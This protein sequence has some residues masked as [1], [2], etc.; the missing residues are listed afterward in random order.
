MKKILI[1]TVLLTI[2]II[3]LG[4]MVTHAYTID[5]D[6]KPINEPFGELAEEDAS[7]ATIIILQIIS[8]GLLYFA[9]PVAV[10][11]IAF[12]GFNMVTGGADSEKLEQSKKH[13]TWAIIGL[14]L[15]IMSYSAVRFV[16]GQAIKAASG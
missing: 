5:P 1:K 13:L 6:F 4:S 2:L 16:I 8:G 7:S 14:V 10:I 9:A 12:A 11:M 15:I 3:I